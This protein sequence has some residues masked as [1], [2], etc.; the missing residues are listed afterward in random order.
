MNPDVK[1]KWLTALRSGEYKQ[2]AMRLYKK[3]ND[4]YCCLGVLCDLYGK[5]NG[6]TWERSKYANE[7]LFRG[8]ATTLPLVVQEWAGL[9]SDNPVLGSGWATIAEYNDGADNDGEEIQPHTFADIADM[10]E[11]H[12]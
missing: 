1:A 7:W 5:E 4:S 9:D 10:I 12:L 6:E 11:E 3:R 2:G 8:A